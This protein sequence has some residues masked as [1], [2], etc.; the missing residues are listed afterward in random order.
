MTPPPRTR[1]ADAV[2]PHGPFAIVRGTL[3][4]GPG[5]VAGAFQGI[6]VIVIGYFK[7]A[8]FGRNFFGV[9]AIATENHGKGRGQHNGAKTPEDFFGHG[10]TV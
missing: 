2:R 6:A 7:L 4:P 8:G 1:F 9:A 5:E 10:I 3:D